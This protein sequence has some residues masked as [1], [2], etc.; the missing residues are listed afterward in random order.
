MTKP[1]KSKGSSTAS[2]KG[3]NQPNDTNGGASRLFATLCDF[4]KHYKVAK[5][6]AIF[7]SAHIDLTQA[8]AWLKHILACMT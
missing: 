8:Y 1:V 3:I 2:N 4:Y 6:L 7:A 5:A